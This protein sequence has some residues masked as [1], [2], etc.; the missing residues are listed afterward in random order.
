MW[1]E[2]FLAGA[3]GHSPIRRRT[4]VP[5]VGVGAGNLQLWDGGGRGDAYG[6]PI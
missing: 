4:T 1:G 3:F 6:V 5:F 2:L